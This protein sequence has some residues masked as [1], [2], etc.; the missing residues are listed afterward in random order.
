NSKRFH[1]TE[2]ESDDGTPTRKQIYLPQ[3]SSSG[4]GDDDEDD[5][6]S[7]VWTELC[8][9]WEFEDVDGEPSERMSF[10]RLLADIQREEDV[11]ERKEKAQEGEVDT[12]ET[13][14]FETNHPYVTA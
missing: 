8:G 6:L 14:V 12:S 11:E 7:A 1:V 4:D 13:V 2:E 9:E 10:S 3:R 5:S